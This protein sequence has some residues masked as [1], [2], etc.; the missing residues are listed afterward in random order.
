MKLIRLKIDDPKGFRSFQPGFEIRF[1]K[2]LNFDKLDEFNP[3]V[4]A[5][6]NG[7][8]KSNILEVLASIFYHIEC[9]HLNYRPD[10]FEYDEETNPNGFRAEFAALNAFEI[11]YF[12]YSSGQNEILSLPFFKMRFIH[13][14]EYI[15]SIKNQTGYSTQPEGR[16]VFLDNDFSQAVLLSNFLLQDKEILKPF[17]QELGI[18]DIKEIVLKQGMHLQQ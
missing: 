9:C 16:L 4:I 7:S 18:E 6:R 8:G 2:E 3:Y 15:D 11:E 12:F 14:D 1:L 17:E 5:G 10:N 13:Y